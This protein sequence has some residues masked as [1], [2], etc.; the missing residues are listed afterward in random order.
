MALTQPEDMRAQVRALLERGVSPNLGGVE[1]TFAD[2]LE[3]LFVPWQAVRAPEPRLLVHNEALA[4]E[5]GVELGVDVFAGGTRCRRVRRPSRRSTPGTSSA[6]T[7][8][9]SV[10]GGRCCWARLWIVRG[11]GATCT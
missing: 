2:S 1:N 9:G 11:A 8:R 5:L 3:G 7:R 4:L 10:T 6:A